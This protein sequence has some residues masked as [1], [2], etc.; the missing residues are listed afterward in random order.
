MLS[1]HVART[2][3]STEPLPFNC[4][5]KSADFAMNM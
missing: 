3:S 4:R 2:E 5:L 1:A